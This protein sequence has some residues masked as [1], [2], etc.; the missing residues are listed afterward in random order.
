MYVENFH[1][2]LPCSTTTLYL[3]LL[4]VYIFFCFT[5]LVQLMIG[6]TMEF[7]HNFFELRVWWW[8]RK[9]KRRYLLV[10]KGNLTLD[11]YSIVHDIYTNLW[12][13]LEIYTYLYPYFLTSR[14]HHLW[15]SIKYLCFVGWLCH[16][17]VYTSLSQLLWC[18]MNK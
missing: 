7:N 4:S 6:N 5:P 16:T 17:D 13:Y 8:S 12:M 9:K 15:R 11:F 14:L 18:N 10:L 2:S 1:Q 3:F